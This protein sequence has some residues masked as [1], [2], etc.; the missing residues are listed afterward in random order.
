[1]TITVNSTKHK[2]NCMKKLI[3]LFT[4]VSMIS[5]SGFSQVSN[6][7]AMFL[8]NFSRLIKWP[9]TQSQGEFIFGVLGDQEVYNSLVAIT[10]GKKVGLQPI[11][12][13]LYKDTK[14]IATCHVLFVSNSK[15]SQFSDVLT[16]VQNKGSL[17]VTEKKGMVNS[18]ST[19]DLILAGDKLRYVLNEENARKNNL[20]LSKNLQDMALKG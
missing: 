9:D 15:I 16:R 17:V 8:L 19:I 7:Q 14:E 1:M 4:L 13:K 3:T 6:A 20:V 5:L 2:I 18:G 12:V 10:A 11:V